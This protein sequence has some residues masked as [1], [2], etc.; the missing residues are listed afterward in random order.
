MQN[1]TFKAITITVPDSRCHTALEEA[2]NLWASEEK[3]SNILH[4]HYYH[5]V[6]L[7]VQGYQVIYQE[8]LPVLSQPQ[9]PA[10]TVHAE[11]SA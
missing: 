6:H 1:T 4:V 11:L 10:V 5:D 2:F 7:R 8:T 3:P 9:V